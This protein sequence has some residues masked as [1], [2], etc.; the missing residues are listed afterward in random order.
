MITFQ[1]LAL[2]DERFY[3]ASVF[4]WWTL[5]SI[6]SAFLSCK[7]CCIFFSATSF[8]KILKM[9]LP[10]S[11]FWHLSTSPP[12]LCPTYIWA[13]SPCTHT[14]SLP[15]PDLGDPAQISWILMR[16]SWS[17]WLGWTLHKQDNLHLPSSLLSAPPSLPSL[18]SQYNN[19]W[20]T[21]HTHTHT[22]T[23]TH[24]TLSCDMS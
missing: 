7:S 22:H 21:Y 13:S 14:P 16:L 1:K 10:P 2:F 8:Q 15:T 4:C 24:A 5:Y 9:S 17:S 3:I 20:S 6:V 19:P 12:R 18:L 11:L 23:H